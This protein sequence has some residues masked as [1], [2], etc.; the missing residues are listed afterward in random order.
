MRPSSPAVLPAFI[1]TFCLLAALAGPARAEEFQARA[2]KIV[3][4]SEIV[5][6]DG[7]RVK[8]I[9]VHA[10]QVRHSY[11]SVR[12]M[13]ERA[14]AENARLVQ[15]KT[16]RIV[17]DAA[18]KDSQGRL[19][20]YVYAG[21]VFVNLEIIRL[22]WAMASDSEPNRRYLTDFRRMEAQAKTYGRGLWAGQVEF[23]LQEKL[24]KR[25][26]VHPTQQPGLDGLRPKEPEPVARPVR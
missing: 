7:R 26:G 6:G 8:Y 25:R 3:S 16:L 20:A 23:A 22:G 13:G 9:G 5:L 21:D 1:T 2:A 14:R 24:D 15:D 10:P 18:Q 11:A 4:G 12:Y 19:L 17:T